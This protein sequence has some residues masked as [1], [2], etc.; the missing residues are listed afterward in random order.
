MSCN[1]II[2]TY[3]TL[4]NNES[5]P[6]TIKA[7]LLY[8]KH[9]KVTI[10]KMEHTTKEQHHYIQQQININDPMI[11]S[12]MQKIYQMKHQENQTIHKTKSKRNSILTWVTTG[13][14]IL[15]GFVTIPLIKIER[16]GL[17]N[18]GNKFNI[19]FALLCATTLIAFAAIF[20]LKNITYL[21]KKLDT[22]QRTYKNLS[23]K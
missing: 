12:I 16:G 22:F 14:L 13:L 20:I 11:D 4:D 8:C 9:C 10:S 3:L 19:S 23:L 2:N 7:H 6:L 17:S 18:F 1:K 5:I 15:S 21:T